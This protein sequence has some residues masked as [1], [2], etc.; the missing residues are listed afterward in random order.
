M[1]TRTQVANATDKTHEEIRQMIANEEIESYRG[2][3]IPDFAISKV[4]GDK[5]LERLMTRHWGISLAQAGWG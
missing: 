2:R 5:T 3:Q 4:F 1:F